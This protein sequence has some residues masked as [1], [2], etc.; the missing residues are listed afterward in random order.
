LAYDF[1][2]KEKLRCPPNWMTNSI[3][4]KDWLAGFLKRNPQ[5]SIRKPQATS[6]SRATSFNRHNVNEFFDLVEDIKK[7]GISPTNFFNAD[8]SGFTTVHRPDGVIAS[9]GRKQVGLITSAERGTLVTVC[10]AVSASGTAIP[11]YFIFPR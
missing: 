9:R 11:P 2:V 7:R 1:A 10:V 5:L 3:A 8:E 4:G 6:L